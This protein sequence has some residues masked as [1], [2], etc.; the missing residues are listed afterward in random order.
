MRTDT[1][2]MRPIPPALIGAALDCLA[3]LPDGHRPDPTLL[4][5]IAHAIGCNEAETPALLTRIRAAAV[6][7]NDPRWPAW[8]VH[9]RT[10]TAKERQAFDAAML[11]IVAELPL[12]PELHF[13][14]DA[15]F[16]A[17]LA[18]AMPH[19]RA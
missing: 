8:P 16:A 14:A 5:A 13:H 19:S 1:T 7:M 9:L 4:V 3:Q 2:S 17:L 18:S 6:V 15:F 10:S 12:G 11:R